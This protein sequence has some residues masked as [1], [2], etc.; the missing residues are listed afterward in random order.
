MLPFWSFYAFTRLQ[1]SLLLDSSSSIRVLQNTRLFTSLNQKL[2]VTIDSSNAVTI[3][4]LIYSMDNKLL[5]SKISG[6]NIYSNQLVENLLVKSTRDGF[7]LIGK[8]SKIK[9]VKLHIFCDDSENIKTT[10]CRPDFLEFVASIDC[11]RILTDSDFAFLPKVTKHIQITSHELLLNERNIR[12]IT[13]FPSIKVTID[14]IINYGKLSEIRT[15]GHPLVY[16]FLIS[17]QIKAGIGVKVNMSKSQDYLEHSAI[18]RESTHIEVEVTPGLDKEAELFQ[19]LI[20]PKTLKIK[21]TGL[22]LANMS[23]LNTL[24]LVG[25]IALKYSLP[26]LTKP[27]P[28]L[29]IL[30]EHNERRTFLLW[31][32]ESVLTYLDEI[33]IS[34]HTV[35][36]T[37]PLY[38]SKSYF[39]LNLAID[40]SC[41]VLKSPISEF[42]KIAVDNVNSV[43]MTGAVLAS[44]DNKL[45]MQ[46]SR[47]GKS[48]IDFCI[49]GEFSVKHFNKI[50]W[51]AYSHLPARVTIVADKITDH[52]I[53][54]IIFSHIIVHMRTTNNY[55]KPKLSCSDFKIPLF[56][57]ATCSNSK[58][59]ITFY[60]D[61]DS[62]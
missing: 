43:E 7:T 17:N 37:K 28:R 26:T 30:D 40:A 42:R 27:L 59:G 24:T 20:D 52:E 44:V 23:N 62:D 34:A 33:Y 25:D 8:L 58:E 2:I 48:V 41:L 35:D 16:D 1:A 39:N 36:L 46:L 5:E 3:T 53:P 21:G 50:L 61:N 14:T 12:S 15:R 51:K 4:D 18:L 32:F 6:I 22:N 47:I 57:F 55:K 38:V 29:N 10:C 13:L 11:L 54:Q 56:S 19:S 31:D 45:I 49:E 9:S 60:A